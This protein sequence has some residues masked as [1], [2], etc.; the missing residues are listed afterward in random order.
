L[1]GTVVRPTPHLSETPHRWFLLWRAEHLG[2]LARH[3]Q[4][5]TEGA[6]CSFAALCKAFQRCWSTSLVFNPTFLFP[7][8]RKRVSHDECGF[9][10]L[11]VTI[12]IAVLALIIAT[13]G[14]AAH[15]HVNEAR[16]RLTRMKMAAA[17]DGAI[18]TVAANLAGGSLSAGALS[19]AQTI[20]VGGI[21]V[22]V[23]ARP[24]A[25]K[26]DLNAASPG[27]LS[28][29]FRAIGIDN[30][31]AAELSDSIV[32]WRDA[33]NFAGANGAEMS[34]YLS[35]GRL[36]GPANG[37]FDSISELRLVLG[38][39]DA[40]LSCLA[41]DITVFTNMTGVEAAY[42]SKHVRDALGLGSSPAR[43][44]ALVGGESIQ[45]GVIFEVTARATDADGNAISRESVL[46]LTGNPKDP[47]WNLA[48]II[49]APVPATVDAACKAFAA[50]GNETHRR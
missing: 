4:L 16:G 15:R 49:P 24:E 3:W 20:T 41:A 40:L 42:S 35:A 28:A 29:L 43:S 2:A 18:T 38:A 31:R 30:E 27:L 11:A 6:V 17:L 39:D 8:L 13:V 12:A 36:Y 5:L 37:N 1:V 34:E 47:I 44:V 33:D 46:R 23:S 26:I 14:D 10:L 21:A 45:P 7:V 22:T 50:E 48:N 25:S 9:A 19:I 32:D